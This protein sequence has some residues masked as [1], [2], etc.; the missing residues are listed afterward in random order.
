MPQ[1]QAVLLS[2]PYDSF[3]P[4]QDE[5]GVIDNI[6]FC[7]KFTTRMSWTELQKYEWIGK[8][9]GSCLRVEESLVSVILADEYWCM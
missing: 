6:H 4:P 2:A 7:H 3:D 9:M 1:L 5:D 8:L